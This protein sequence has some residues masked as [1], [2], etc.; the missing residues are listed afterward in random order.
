MRESVEHVMK[1]TTRPPVMMV[2]GDGAWLRDSDGRRAGYLIDHYFEERE[3]VQE[4]KGIRILNWHRPLAAYM[5]AFLAA[6][7]QLTWF[8]E[9][10]PEP[11]DDK[12]RNY[13]RLPWFVTMEWRKA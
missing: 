9:P 13:R 2:E 8:G 1:I 12:A 4:W 3:V 11:V 7:L 6:G 5:Q 10:V